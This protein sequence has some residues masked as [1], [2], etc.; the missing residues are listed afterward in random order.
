MALGILVFK[1]I[2]MA[3]W[4]ENILFDASLHITTAFLVLYIIWFF[5]DQEKKLYTPFFI[6]AGVVLF[7][8]SLQRIEANAH[9]DIGILLGVLISLVSIYSSEKEV[10]GKMIE[11]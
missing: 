10:L 8:I 11:F 7:V 4:G 9:N 1:F 3:I 6:L 5:V 2:P